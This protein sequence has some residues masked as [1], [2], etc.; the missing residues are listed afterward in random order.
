MGLGQVD[1]HF[2]QRTPNLEHVWCVGL[3]HE[4]L[5]DQDK[6]AKLRFIILSYEFTGLWIFLNIGMQS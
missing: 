3:Q 6:S 1:G 4:W 2:N 5:L